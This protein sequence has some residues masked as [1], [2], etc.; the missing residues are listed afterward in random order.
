MNLATLLADAAAAR[1]DSPALATG[2]TIVATYA[3][4]ADRSARLAASLRGRHGL[5]AGDRVAIAM[6]N[7]PEYSEILFAAWHAG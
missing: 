7:A 6:K 4:H 3:A 1:P 2:E 5:A